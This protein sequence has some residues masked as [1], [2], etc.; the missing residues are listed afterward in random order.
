MNDPTK[1]Y[2]LTFDKRPDYLYV[3]LKADASHLKKAV[4]YWR[5]IIDTCREVNCDR[6]LV[7]QEI[8]GKLS[9]AETFALA[10]EIT[11]MGIYDIKIAFVDAETA[12]YEA[13]QFGQLVGSNRGAW[14]QVFTTVPEAENWLLQGSR[15]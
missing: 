10:S 15:K 11:A 12:N 8:P 2:E 14:A 6:L 7:V 13:H 9:T 4:D 1:P 3:H 5:A